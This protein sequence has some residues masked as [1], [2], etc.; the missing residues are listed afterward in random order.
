M[1]YSNCR[2]TN[3]PAG[4]RV[5]FYIYI[6][7]QILCCLEECIVVGVGISDQ[8]VLVPFLA[9]VTAV[10]LPYSTV[11]AASSSIGTVQDARYL[12][13]T[14]GS[15][16]NF[17]NCFVFKTV[18]TCSKLRSI[19]PWHFFKTKV[20]IFAAKTVFSEKITFCLD[21]LIGS[22]EE[23]VCLPWL[24]EHREKCVHCLLY[25]IAGEC[26]G[27]SFSPIALHWRDSSCPFPKKTLLVTG[28]SETGQLRGFRRTSKKS[29]R[30]W[31]VCCGRFFVQVLYCLILL[32][33]YVKNAICVPPL[34]ATSTELAGGGDSSCS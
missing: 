20:K 24:K 17:T 8:G 5:R 2:C 32:S 1:L 29:P 26:T 3:F 15:A 25:A 9:N 34:P 21:R 16:Q 10:C 33:V 12:R 11:R 28:F 18:A 31:F 19:L 22:G 27:F 7:T 23:M 13:V 6:F 14:I 30:K 4:F